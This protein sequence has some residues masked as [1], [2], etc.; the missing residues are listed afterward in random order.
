M[1]ISPSPKGK[2]QAHCKIIALHEFLRFPEKIALQVFE[3]IT[4]AKKSH[5]NIFKKLQSQKRTN[6]I[7]GGKYQ[8]QNACNAIG[9]PGF[10]GITNLSG[11]NGQEKIPA[12][13]TRISLPILGHQNTHMCTTRLIV[14]YC[15]R[16]MMDKILGHID[17][18][19]VHT[20]SIFS[21]PFTPYTLE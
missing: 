15:R 6:R 18:T 21:C 10:K 14:P 4:T 7:F 9:S 16:W 5:R 1:L 12:V 17:K 20:A 11:V 19:L 8:L 2:Q 13:W 3:K